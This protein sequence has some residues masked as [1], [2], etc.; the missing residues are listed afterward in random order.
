MIQTSMRKLAAVIP[1]LILNILV[2]AGTVLLVLDWWNRSQPPA[3]LPAVVFPTEIQPTPAPTDAAPAQPGPTP[4]ALAEQRALKVVDVLG[5][6]DDQ[7]EVV[8]L[9]Y[10]G[11]AQLRLAGWKIEDNQGHR[12]TFPNFTLAKGGTVRIYTRAGLD[13]AA[14]LYWGLAQAVW[15]SGKTL[16]VYDNLGDVRAS[17]KV[18]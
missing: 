3:P 4:A 11:E 17:Y 10:T 15:Q 18:P 7:N 1:F 13:T 16:V 8:V 5:A 2:S 14:E 6:G 9:Q 12:Y